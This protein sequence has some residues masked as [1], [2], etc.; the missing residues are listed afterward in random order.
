[1]NLAARRLATQ[2]SFYRLLPGTEPAP[3]VYASRVPESPDR[4]LFNGVTYRD[5]SAV[6]PLLPELASWYEEAGVRAWTVWVLPGDEELAGA[7]AEAGHRLDATPEAMGAVLAELDLDGP[8]VATGCAWD[9][10]VAVNAAAYGAP[11]EGLQ[12]LR[13]AGD[14]VRLYGTEGAAIVLAIHDHDGDAGVTYVAARPEARGRG[15]VAALLRQ[16]L[17]DAAARGCTTTTLESTKLGR[18]V[19]ERVGYRALGRLEMW[20]RRRRG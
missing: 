13:L 14:G 9:D 12:P 7:L 3:G 2:Q 5:P 19:Y 17:R 8:D 10:L 15:L 18:P 20:E 6:L 11:A 4:S 1:V 16:A